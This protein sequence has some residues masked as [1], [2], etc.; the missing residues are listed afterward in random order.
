MTTTALILHR[1]SDYDAWRT[2][3]DS[4]DDLRRQGGVIS[5]EVLKPVGGDDLVAVTHEFETP[6]AARAFVS[7]DELKNA[8]QRGGVDPDSVQLHRRER[9]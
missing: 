4:A 5:A 7:N 6:E 1:V 8:M 2:A 3:Y 9:D